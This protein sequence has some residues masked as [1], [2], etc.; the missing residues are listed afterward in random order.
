MASMSDFQNKT[1]EEM[2]AMSHCNINNAFHALPFG[3]CPHN[4]HCSCPPEILHNF[5]LGKCNDL[6]RDL[7]FTDAAN[8]HISTNFSWVYPFLKCQSERNVPSLHPFRDRISSAKSLKAKERY[9]R[10]FA[11]Y[12][13]MMNP[14]LV[15]KLKQ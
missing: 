12:L 15:K 3:G 10:V 9:A 8:E 2:D 7:S 13:S 6:G 1:K 14:Y 5:Q 11:V 4:I